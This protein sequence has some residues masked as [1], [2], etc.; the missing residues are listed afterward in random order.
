MTYYTVD[1]NPAQKS[2]G[3]SSTIR[4]EFVLIQTGFASVNTDM[5]L[6]GVAAGQ[7]WTGSHDFT[8]ASL[9]AATQSA[10]DSSTK[11]A[12]TAFCAALAFSSTL[13]AQAGNSGKFMTT[14]GSTASWGT[15]GV[16]GGGTGITSYTVGDMLYASGASTLSKLADV[17]TGSALISG[18]IGVAPSW[19]K[20]GLTTHVSG[21]L[22]AANGGTGVANNA[23]NT[24]TYSG[25][26]GLTLT[27]SNTTSLNLPASGTLATLNGSETLTNKVLTTP[28][29]NNSD[30]TNIRVAGFNQEV[31]NGNSGTTK[32]VTMSAGM[33]QKLTLTGNVAL[34][35]DWTG[36]LAGNY[37]LRVIQDGSGAHTVVYTAGLTSTRWLNTASAP[38]PNTT[39]SSES[40]I[41]MFYNGA[42]AAATCQSLSRIGAA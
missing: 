29:L 39:A 11:V 9:T 21:V 5:L 24:L 38:A 31:D 6:R 15:A 26:F 22:G 33:K 34:T 13:P 30:I 37:Q 12:T 41:S 20:V 1:G 4:A 7:T 28:N 36:A 14:D 27:L 8:G 25:N 23:A 18:G 40:L 2:R 35:L 19:G 42:G 16:A 10:G 3:A 17:A 32:T